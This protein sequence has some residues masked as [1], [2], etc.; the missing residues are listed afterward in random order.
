MHDLRTAAAWGPTHTGL[1]QQEPSDSTLHT[2]A[3]A[4][5]FAA[6]TVAFFFAP[7]SFFVRFLRSFICL[8]DLF[9]GASISPFC[10]P[11]SRED[12]SISQSM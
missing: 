2:A 4:Y 7:R 10:R 5:F 11:G 6:A 1:L 3:A 9:C 8:R 12:L